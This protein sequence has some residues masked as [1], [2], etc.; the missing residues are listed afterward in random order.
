MTRPASNA[1]VLNRGRVLL[2]LRGHTA[3]WAPG[4]WA[5]PGGHAEASE[6]PYSALLRE[7]REETGLRAPLFIQG[8]LTSSPVYLFRVVSP[9]SRVRLL[10]GEHDKFRWVFPQ[11]VTQFDLAP[12]VLPLIRRALR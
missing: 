9:T 4:R 5:L 11:N 7:L 1:V 3:P 8:P 10:D 6:S 2:L 12:G